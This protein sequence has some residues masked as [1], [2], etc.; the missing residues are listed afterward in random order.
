MTADPLAKRGAFGFTGA[1]PPFHGLVGG[2]LGRSRLV[3]ARHARRNEWTDARREV[4]WLTDPRISYPISRSRHHPSL[5]PPPGSNGRG[6]PTS[7]GSSC[8]CLAHPL[9]LVLRSSTI[10]PSHMV[11][12][13]TTTSKRRTKPPPR[14]FVRFNRRPR[15]PRIKRRINRMDRICWT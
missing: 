1:F 11:D 3:H 15:P 10:Q 14:V 13:A 5:P 7:P 8:P 2:A 6:V 12:P 4:G 9:C